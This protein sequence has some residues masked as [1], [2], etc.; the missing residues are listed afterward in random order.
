MI[1]GFLVAVGIAAMLTAVNGT[2]IASADPIPYGGGCILYPDNKAMT[3]DSL[4]TRC[5]DEQ[6]G[7]I[8]AASPMGASPAGTKNGWIATP[9][10]ITPLASGIWFGKN[11][12]TGPDGGFL[13]NR[14]TGAALEAWLANVYRGTSLYDGKPAWVLDYIPSPTPPLL[15]EIREVTPGVWYGMSWWRGAVVVERVTL[16]TF[17]VA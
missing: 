11:F 12:Y 17:I 1:R 4:R 5:S 6:L 7:A 10:M 14:L 13:Q 3:I 8:Y 15:D 16:L 2:A 9:Q